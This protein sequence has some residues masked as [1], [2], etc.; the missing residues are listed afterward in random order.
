ME[1]NGRERE[2]IS[3]M[4]C[5]EERRKLRGRENE[6]R[7]KDGYWIKVTQGLRSE[8]MTQQMR[9]QSKRRGPGLKNKAKA[10]AP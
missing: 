5:H 4:M 1:G 2:D 6:I 9:R 7:G 8:E 10:E 3:G